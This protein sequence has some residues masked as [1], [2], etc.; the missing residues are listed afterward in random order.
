MPSGLRHGSGAQQD[1]SSSNVGSYSAS[2]VLRSRASHDH[3][4]PRPAT[5]MFLRRAESSS[6]LL[7]RSSS[8]AVSAGVSASMAIKAAR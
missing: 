4:V 8:Q 5:S 7:A 2:L 1:V 3:A 6:S